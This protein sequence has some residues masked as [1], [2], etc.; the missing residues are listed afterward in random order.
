MN[1]KLVIVSVAVALLIVVTITVSSYAY[2]TISNKEGEETVI[3]SGTMTLKLTD[4][5]TITANNLL[6][7]QYIEKEFSIE[8]TGNIDS[9]Y[10]VYLSEVINSFADKTD[11]VYEIT[12]NDGGYNT[13]NQVQVPSS[14]HKIINNQSIEVGK[15]HHYKLKL[16]FLNK[17]TNQDANQGKVFSA[18]IQINEYKD[19]ETTVNYY[20]NNI[21]VN[22]MPNN[23]N[24]FVNGTCDK[25]ASISFDT[26]NWNY[27]LININQKNTTCSLYFESNLTDITVT[28][29]PTK[30]SYTIGD[31]LDLS[32]LEVTANYSDGT[33][34]VITSGLTF[35]MNDNSLLSTE[36]T[37][38]IVISYT[39]NNITKTCNLPIEVKEKYAD[40]RLVFN[41]NKNTTKGGT[42]TEEDG[43]YTINGQAFLESINSISLTK[44]TFYVE[45][46]NMTRYT[47]TIYT[48]TGPEFS[49]LIIGTGSSGSY[50][51]NRCF[52]IA[53]GWGGDVINGFTGTG[54]VLQFSKSNLISNDWNRFA[55]TY[56]GTTYK[57]YL[58]GQLKDSYSS[59]TIMNT[60]LYVGGWPD[61]YYTGSG[62][63]WGFANGVYRNIKVYNIA[64]PASEL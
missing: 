8:N 44:G 41:L 52:G 11:L 47:D 45:V 31:N 37:Y 61:G 57:I 40:N 63:L 35:S 43:E 59:A 17:N 10:D 5:N 19:V 32:G 4:G 46:K 16:T 3:K 1:K 56:D 13:T 20:L 50:T 29:N 22:D 55:I 21:S 27:E 51:Q 53:D 36:G 23:T 62:N 48:G 2:F 58:N 9:A 38:N 28:N 18:K 12:S 25:N 24:T 26:T 39:E 60:K 54:G 34:S 7:G 6:P 42:I 33:S 64:L 49:A 15:T 30:T 14:S